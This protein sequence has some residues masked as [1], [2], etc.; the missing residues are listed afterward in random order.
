MAL[1]WI[2]AMRSR[3]V[4][5]GVPKGMPAEMTT[6]CPW[7]PNLSART[8]EIGHAQGGLCGCNRGVEPRSPV[9]GPCETGSSGAE[10][11]V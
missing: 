1:H 7:S 6:V 8:Q 9:G 11:V 10:D 5:P 4:V 2:C 3:F